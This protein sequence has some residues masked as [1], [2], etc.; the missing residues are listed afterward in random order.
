M[1]FL[2]TPSARRATHPVTPDLSRAKNFYPRP[3]QGGRHSNTTAVS[4]AYKFLSTPSA[5]RATSTAS[6][7]A[8]PSRPF[9]ST[10]SARRATAQAA[11]DAKHPQHFYPRPPQGGRPTPAV[12]VKSA[13]V[14]LSTP[15]AR[16]ATVSDFITV[17]IIAISIHALRK[18]GDFFG[19]VCWSAS[20]YFYPRPPQGGRRCIPP[21]RFKHF[22]IS[23]HALRKEGDSAAYSAT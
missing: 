22:L 1:Q 7:C 20:A 13:Y 11:K 9:L 23:I 12:P 8:L 4:D 16:R 17:T 21:D 2:S 18:E 15:S 6:C 5:R 19:V 14:F 10:P 3:P